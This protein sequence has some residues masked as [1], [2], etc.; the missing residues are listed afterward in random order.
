MAARGRVHHWNQISLNMVVKLAVCLM[1]ALGLLFYIS[2][3]ISPALLQKILLAVDFCNDK[4]NNHSNAPN[5][6]ASN[7]MLSNPSFQNGAIPFDEYNKG[8]DNETVYMCQKCEPRKKQENPPKENGVFKQLPKEAGTSKVNCCSCAPQLM[9]AESQ[10][11][12]TLH[13]STKDNPQ[14]QE[15]ERRIGE[16]TGDPNP[17]RFTALI[18]VMTMASKIDR[19]NLLR[20]AYRVQSSPDAHISVRFVMGAFEEAG[21]VEKTLVGME[22]ATY[23]DIILLNCTE[24]LNEGKTFTFFSSLPD[25]GL[26]YDYVMKTDDDSYLRFENL[27]RSLKGLPRTDLYYGYILPCDNDDPYS[28]YMAGM[29][30]LI[31]WDLVLWIR[32]SPIPRNNSVGT[33]DQ[34][35]GDWFNEGGVAKNRVNEKPLFYDHPEFGGTCAHEL[36]PETILLHQV[37]TPERW[38]NVLDFFEKD[39]ISNALS[40]ASGK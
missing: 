6:A 37:K 31:S 34:L 9:D 28:W 20:L 15:K 22:N 11:D 36:V 16:S 4:G 21:G 19:R 12:L 27:G 17:K 35:V 33:E 8:L 10:H 39:R 29:G 18:G 40:L 32:N 3:F 7:V 14:I 2:I 25:R 38:A 13:N 24:N 1:T 30:Y 5:T 23:G 26:E